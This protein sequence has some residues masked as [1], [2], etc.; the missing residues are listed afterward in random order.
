S[1]IS[2]E[3]S[4]KA[5][6]DATNNK[7][8]ISAV[9]P[10]SNHR[11]GRKMDVI[12][13]AGCNEMGCLEIRQKDD[14]TKEIKDV[15]VKMPVVMQDMLLQLACTEELLQKIHIVGFVIVGIYYT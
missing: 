2:K 13:C 8:C 9:M 15:F 7:R 4:S 14:Q 5:N 6:A 1:I 12:Y 11:M 3:A 10:A